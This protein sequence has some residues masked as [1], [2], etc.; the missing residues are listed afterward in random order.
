MVLLAKVLVSMDGK[1][2]WVDNVYIER[3]WRTIK[4]EHILLFSY[5]SVSELRSSI[6]QCI[7]LY[8]NQRLHQS[9]SYKPPAEVYYCSSAGSKERKIEV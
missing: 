9:L 6:S 4:Y 7:E 2:R 5:T 3:F 8:N 1:G